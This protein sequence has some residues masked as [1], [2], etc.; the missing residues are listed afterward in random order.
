MFRHDF[1]KFPNTNL[2]PK[3]IYPPQSKIDF[4]NFN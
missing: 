4:I 3:F 1:G 2:I